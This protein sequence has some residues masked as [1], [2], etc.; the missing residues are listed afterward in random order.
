MVQTI[1]LPVATTFF[2]ARITI[3]AALASSP[4]VGSSMKMIEG[5]ATSSTAIVSRFR[6][7]VERPLVIITVRERSTLRELSRFAESAFNNDVFPHP[8]GPRNSLRDLTWYDFLMSWREGNKCADKLANIG[9]SGVWGT[10]IL[11]N[12]PHYLLDISYELML[13]CDNYLAG[14]LASSNEGNFVLSSPIFISLLFLGLSRQ[15]RRPDQT[16][17][18]SVVL[19][20]VI[21]VSRRTVGKNKLGIWVIA[22]LIFCAVIGKNTW[23]Y[24]SG[25]WSKKEWVLPEIANTAGLAIRVAS[26]IWVDC[27]GELAFGLHFWSMKA[28]V[29]QL[30][31]LYTIEETVNR[32]SHHGNSISVLQCLFNFLGFYI[33]PSMA[34]CP[35]SGLL[36]F[37]DISDC[38]AE[39]LS[40]FATAFMG[41]GVLNTIPYYAMQTMFIPTGIRDTLETKIRGF[42]WN[43]GTHHLIKWETV[44]QHRIEAMVV[45]EFAD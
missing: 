32:L 19:H 16:S 10:S 2:T 12:P 8:G 5:F 6:C 36:F 28:G 34:P 37:C 39:S 20:R 13:G 26:K 27:F 17:E 24:G 23:P 42:L 43:Q 11:E 29:L 22:F 15:I 45:L 3:A 9:Q 33:N 35:L 30:H 1:V 4:V 14:V 31:P 40:R 44:T 41:K 25:V 21:I 18:L 38:S 7:S